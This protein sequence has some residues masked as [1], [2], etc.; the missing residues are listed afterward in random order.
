MKDFFLSYSKV[1]KKWAEWIA[2]QLEDAGYT[3]VLQAWDFSP[4]SNFV[5]KMQEAAATTQRTIV[6]LSE[7]YLRSLP[8][9]SEWAAAFARDPGGNLA[10]VLPVR[11]QPCSPEGLLRQLVYVDLVGIAEESARA[12]LLAGVQHG[13]MKPRSAPLF[14]GGPSEQ[15]ARRQPYPGARKGRRLPAW[16]LRPRQ[17]DPPGPGSQTPE[18]SWPPE[19]PP[20]RIRGA[21]DLATRLPWLV[22]SIG[23]SPLSLVLVDIDGQNGINKRFGAAVGDDVIATIATLVREVTAAYDTGRCGDDTFYAV[24]CRTPAVRA[25]AIAEDIRRAV[26]EYPWESIAADLYVACSIGVVEARVSERAE[27]LVGRAS[28]GMARARRRGGDQ[29]VVGPRRLPKDMKGLM[30][31][32]S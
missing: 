4:G 13:R 21:N 22:D 24:L 26:Q 27:D 11:V 5:L 23:D 10:A 31:T 6:V 16:E 3:T 9:A 32:F 29:V 25:S 14:P 7:N 20:A 28:Y 19:I 30:W 18:P 8:A 2:W 15:D 1:D 12:Y 17:W